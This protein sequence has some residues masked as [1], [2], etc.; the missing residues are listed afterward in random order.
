MGK[1]VDVKDL[2]FPYYDSS[3]IKPRLL[4]EQTLGR[5]KKIRWEER[6]MYFDLIEENFQNL[7]N[8][9]TKKERF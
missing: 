1:A 2:Q 3:S 6:L 8:Q 7:F 9:E 4:A 5:F